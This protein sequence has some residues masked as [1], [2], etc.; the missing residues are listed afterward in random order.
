MVFNLLEYVLTNQLYVLYVQVPPP[1]A[2]N[3]HT[4]NP[5]GGK[6]TKKYSMT[7]KPRDYAKITITE[8]PG[9]YRPSV[10]MI[11]LYLIVCI[12]VAYLYNFNIQLY[13]LFYDR[14]W[15]SCH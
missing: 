14:S 8:G 4:V 5:I 1:G 15:I 11:T 13:T 6:G 10:Y 12:L 9:M 7:G 2:Y 3:P